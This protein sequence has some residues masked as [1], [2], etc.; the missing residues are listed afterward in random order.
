M[1]SVKNRKRLL[2]REEM[3]KAVD[4]WEPKS[5]NILALL[6]MEAQDAKSY[7]MGRADERRVSCL[8]P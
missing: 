2:T 3:L 7:A 6:L 5:V 8:N 4:G 1:R